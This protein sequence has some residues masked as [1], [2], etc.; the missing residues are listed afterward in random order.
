LEYNGSGVSNSKPIK[1]EA[2]PWNSREFSAEIILV[3]LGISV[4]KIS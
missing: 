1:I 4:F 2:T 3:P